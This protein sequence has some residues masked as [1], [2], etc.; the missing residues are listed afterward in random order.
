MKIYVSRLDDE[1][2]VVTI[3]SGDTGR[4]VELMNTRGNGFAIMGEGMEIP[5]A[6]VD[7]RLL[8]ADWITSD[9][10]LAIEAHELGH[11]R[12]GSVEEPVAEREGIRLLEMAGHTT[13]A[14][15]LRGRGI[16]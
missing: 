16:V 8:K 4:I 15:I 10:L 11:I 7:G 5:I 9:H 13:A 6:V 12:T 14:D 3:E 2:L 1:T